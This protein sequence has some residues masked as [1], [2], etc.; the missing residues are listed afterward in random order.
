[1]D[2]NLLTPRDW[3]LTLLGFYFS[4]F[5]RL[6]AKRS[7]T[8]WRPFSLSMDNRCS[9]T[10]QQRGA[11]ITFHSLATADY[12]GQKM[13]LATVKDDGHFVLKQPDG[14]IGLPAHE[15]TLMAEWKVEPSG[16]QFNGKY[17]SPE[18]PLTKITVR[19]NQ[20]TFCPRSTSQPIPGEI[21]PVLCGTLSRLLNHVCQHLSTKC[22]LSAIGAAV[23]S[24]CERA[25]TQTSTAVAE[26]S[27]VEFVKNEIPMLVYPRFTA[28][29]LIGHSM[30]SLLGPGFKT[31]LCLEEHDLPCRTQACRF[32]PRWHQGLPRGTSGA[33][34][35]SR[36][37]RYDRHDGRSRGARVRRLESAQRRSTSPGLH[38]HWFLGAAGLLKGYKATTHWL[39]LMI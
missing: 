38:R 3:C 31:R 1:M 33:V 6:C 34:H 4:A 5:R 13:W 18:T 29:D 32:V 25:A 24:G 7:A 28:L 26:K 22:L 37:R 23:V 16:D 35:S 30:F 12:E 8:S 19:W 11:V 14:A 36:H 10:S 27:R 15:Y 17:A 9:R 20:S 2:A 39:L 21:F